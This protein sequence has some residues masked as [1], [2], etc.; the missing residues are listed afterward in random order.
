MAR[1]ASPTNTLSVTSRTIDS[2]SV[3]VAASVSV[4]I[5]TNPGP[6]IWRPDTLTATCSAAVGTS[7]SQS[8][9]SRHA[10]SRIHAPKRVIS[11]LS[12]AMAI[13][14]MVATG[15]L[16]GWVQ[17]SRASTPTSKPSVGRTIGW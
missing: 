6:R 8:A 10:W 13:M 11:P 16:N 4:T 2:G 15:P 5:A 7:A 12:S 17:R 9:R 14:S 3:P 1:S